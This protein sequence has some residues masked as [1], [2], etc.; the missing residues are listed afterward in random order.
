MDP[1]LSDTLIGD[2]FNGVIVNPSQTNF[3]L[4]L[5]LQFTYST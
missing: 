3:A 4:E 1:L 2:K 5:G